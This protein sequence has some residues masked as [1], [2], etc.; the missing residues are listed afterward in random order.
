MAG[1]IR[2]SDI[3]LVRER[4]PIADVVG[5]RVTLRPAGGGTVKG[6]CPFH[7][8]KTPSFNVNPAKGVYFCYGCSEG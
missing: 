7:D 5:Q 4:S 2:D 3:A 8:E 1:R 6:L